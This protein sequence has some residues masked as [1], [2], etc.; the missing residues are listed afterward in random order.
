ME[1]HKFIDPDWT[2]G[3]KKTETITSKTVATTTNELPTTKPKSVDAWTQ[4]TDVLSDSPDSSQLEAITKMMENTLTNEEIIEFTEKS[5]PESCY[6]KCQKAKGSVMSR[7]G[8]CDLV[9]II[10]SSKAD[11][12]KLID[13]A[14]KVYPQLQNVERQRQLNADDVLLLSQEETI[15]NHIDTEPS[16]FKINR[17]FVAVTNMS[18]NDNKLSP[19][20]IKKVLQIRRFTKEKK[21]GKLAWAT[22]NATLTTQVRKL[23]EYLFKSDNV[24]L[25]FYGIPDERPV[26]YTKETG[27]TKF[28]LNT[29]RRI[30][31]ISAKSGASTHANDEEEWI[32]PKNKRRTDTVLIKPINEVTSYAEI[33]A[34]IKTGIDIDDICIK[35]DRIR[36][37]KE[38]HIELKIREDEDKQKKLVEAIKNVTNNST[39]SKVTKPQKTIFIKDL[40]ESVLEEELITAIC[41]KVNITPQETNVKLASR[42]NKNGLKYAFVKLPIDAANKL[43]QLKKITVGWLRCRMEENKSPIKCYNCN[44]FG[45]LASTCKNEDKMKG[46]CLNCCQQGHTAPVCKNDSLCYVCTENNNHKAGSR[47]CPEYR[48]AES[49]NKNVRAIFKNQNYNQS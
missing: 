30:S 37:T 23:C 2:E 5:W 19:N 46:K 45:H 48:K 25:A 43:L 1:K 26:K 28:S 11:N 42:P 36:K 34:K 41:K 20:T 49:D 29:N 31:T 33:I 27:I 40:E 10:D 8:Q 18:E 15:L 12:C 7:Y 21:C 6:R 14:A 3:D 9:L 4:T 13:E 17:A 16:E 44:L 47:L 32:T 38:G 24:E 35:V 39:E 22:N